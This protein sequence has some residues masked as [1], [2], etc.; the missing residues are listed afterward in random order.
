MT[1]TAMSTSRYEPG[2]GLTLWGREEEE[3]ALAVLRSRSLF[4]YYGPDLQRRTE[5]FEEAFAASLG[6]PHVT[7]VSSGTAALACALIG[8]GIPAGAEVIIP[9]MTFVACVSAVVMARGVPVFAEIDDTL[10]LDPRRIEERVSERTFAV[11]P[12]HLANVAADM[13]PILEVA[14][15][16]GLRVLEDSAQAVGVRY[17]GRRVGSM[18]DAG[19]FSFQLDKN[20]TAGEGGAVCTTD[21]TVHERVKRYQDQGGQFTTSR[22]H[23]RG[24]VV[25][26]PF[27]GANLRMTELAASILGAQLGKLDPMLTRLRDVSRHVR[28]ELSDVIGDWRRMPDEEGSG[29][30]VT[31][32]LETAERARRFVTALNARGVTARTLYSGRGVQTNPSVQAGRTPWGIEWSQPA[33]CVDSERISERSVTVDLGAAMTD[34]DVDWLVESMR[35]A[36]AAIDARE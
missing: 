13:D 28:G 33:P 23:V 9:S 1:G 4:R 15:R 5:A 19:A 29:G 21:P 24:A 30:D 27:V 6:V 18:G 3:A 17:R 10:T 16:R 12:V 34:G 35:M 26:E 2:R 25:E 32:F 31:A 36:H 14:R 8:M 7:A 22:G 20:I 11:M